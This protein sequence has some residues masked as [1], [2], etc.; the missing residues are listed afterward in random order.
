[1]AEV[2]STYPITFTVPIEDESMSPSFN[3]GEYAL[4]EPNTAPELEDDVLV[5]MGDGRIVIKRLLSQRNA[6]R[7]GSYNSNEIISATGNNNLDVLRCTSSA[8]TEN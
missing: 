7:L 4:V 1:M 3:P 6:I 5:K 2:N 8:S